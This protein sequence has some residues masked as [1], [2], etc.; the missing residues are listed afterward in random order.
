MLNFQGRYLS[1]WKP[2]KAETKETKATMATRQ[3]W[4]VVLRDEHIAARAL[5]RRGADPNQKDAAGRTPLWLCGWHDLSL[6]TLL[7]DHGAEVDARDGD[8][9]T[10]LAA[11]A[12][13]GA[14]DAFAAL[15][16]AGAD[17]DSENCDGQTPLFHAA[18]F[19]RLEAVVRLLD[20]GAKRSQDAFGRDPLWIAASAGHDMIVDLFLR[21]SNELPT[22][23]SGATCLHA[24][25]LAGHDHVATAILTHVSH[26]DFLEA[27]DDQG[28]SALWLAARDGH[29]ALLRTLLAAGADHSSSAFSGRTAIEICE[30]HGHLDALDLLEHHSSGPGST[31]QS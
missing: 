18:N 24:A 13:N 6:V 30:L 5:L 27:V 17:V 31:D 9:D 21:R 29:L 22:D 8:G 10:P 2:S 20:R 3:L 15:L 14:K 7:V 1:S 11:A 4:G 19:G 25:V 28:R 23:A 26:S 16:D 12:R